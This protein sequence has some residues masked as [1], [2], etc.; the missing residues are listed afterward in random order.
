MQGAVQG[1]NGTLQSIY[2]YTSTEKAQLIWAVAIG[3]IIGTIPY[4]WMY[5]RYG[6]KNVFLSA[7]II[8]LI[9]TSCTPFAAANNYILLLVIRLIQGI[10]YA[11][12][13]AVIGIICVKWAPHDEVAFF[14]SVL[15]V[16][17]PF[18]TVITTAVTG[19]LCTSSFGWRSSFYVHSVA[20]A[21]CFIL[22]YIVYSDDP[23]SHSSVTS[24]ELA[25]IQK[26]KSAAHFEQKR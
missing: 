16:F 17:S 23:L 7:G 24:K 6:A 14:V 4:N 2:D 15:T 13:F 1:E 19:F 8:S 5:V 10:A 21:V 11:A 22:W 20:G 9:A 12:D 18:A 25:N 26:G 3:T